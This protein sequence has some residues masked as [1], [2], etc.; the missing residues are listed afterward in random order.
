MI[1]FRYISY[2]LMIGALVGGILNGINDRNP[3]NRMRYGTREKIGIVILWPV[4]LGTFLY[5]IFKK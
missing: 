1:V 5:F 2:Y 4:A 3:D